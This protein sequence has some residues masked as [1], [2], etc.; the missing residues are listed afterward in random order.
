MRVVSLVDFLASV[1]ILAA[2][3]GDY[4]GSVSRAVKGSTGCYMFIAVSIVSYYRR[5]ILLALPVPALSRL[6]SA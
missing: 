6:I 2:K 1:L 5:S 4:V 3:A